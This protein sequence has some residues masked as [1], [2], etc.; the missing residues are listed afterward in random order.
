MNVT[1]LFWNPIINFGEDQI[2]SKKLYQGNL[3]VIYYET[4]LSYT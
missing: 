2:Y 4:I 3:V 1:E